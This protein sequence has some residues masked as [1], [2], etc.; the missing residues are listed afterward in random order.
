[1]SSVTITMVL[2]ALLG[3]IMGFFSGSRPRLR[4]PTK[5]GLSPR[6]P[7]NTEMHMKT[8]EKFSTDTDWIRESRH[9]CDMNKT[10]FLDDTCLNTTPLRAGSL[11]CQ[12]QWRDFDAT[13]DVCNFYTKDAGIVRISHERW[14]Q[15][16][17]EESFVWDG[18]DWGN[19]RN[20]EHA[21]W[22]DNYRAV[23]GS[24]LGRI[25]EL[26]CGPF[27]QTKT[28]LEKVMDRQKG[29]QTRVTS[30]TLADPLMS[31][32]HSR[33]PSC[34]YR[35]GSLMGY[36]T[37]FIASGGED[38]ML[39]GVYDTVV[40]INVLEHC[41][42]A[43]LVIENLHLAVRD[44]GGMLIFSERWYDT[45]WDRYESD[46]APFWDVMHPINVKRKVIDTLLAHYTPLFVRNFLFEGNYPT[47]EGV[48]F[49][50]VKK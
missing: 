34:S 4:L 8:L 18:K 39:R 46:R 9:A 22:F 36:P 19:D 48:Y 20:E 29:Q 40:M 7:V 49:I 12:T 21:R 31:F 13:Q 25:L 38:L 30:I 17:Q 28:I 45:K 43:L 10:R 3:F 15:A 44:R 37:Q 5:A 24:S 23:N 14:R 1:M 50:G 47:D 27:T 6:E 26:G 2:V 32:Y 41:R 33:V 42:D 35:N 11:S 16:Q